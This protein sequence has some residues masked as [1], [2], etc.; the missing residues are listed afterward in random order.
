MKHKMHIVSPK[1]AKAR[2]FDQ[3]LSLVRPNKCT[4]CNG[5]LIDEPQASRCIMCGHIFYLMG[6]DGAQG[7]FER[8]SGLTSSGERS[9]TVMAATT[10]GRYASAE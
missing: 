9:S 6:V 1:V 8:R 3:L 10:Q 4:R 5:A 7:E 2:P